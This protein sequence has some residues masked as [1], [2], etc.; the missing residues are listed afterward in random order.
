MHE[1]AGIVVRPGGAVGRVQFDAGTRV[2]AVFYLMEKL[3]EAPRQD[4]ARRHE[5]FPFDRALKELEYDESKRLLHKAELLR[6]QNA[7]QPVSS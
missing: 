2:D 3:A 4:V 6:L 1:E 5:W 7:E